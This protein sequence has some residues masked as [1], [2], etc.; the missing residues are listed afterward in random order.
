M[1]F[2]IPCPPHCSCELLLARVA[3]RVSYCSVRKRGKTNRCT[4]GR[5]DGLAGWG[6]LHRGMPQPTFLPLFMVLTKHKWGKQAPSGSYALA[7][8]PPK[9][10]AWCFSLVGSRHGGRQVSLGRRMDPIKN[11]KL[12]ATSKSPSHWCISLRNGLILSLQLTRLCRW[13]PAGRARRAIEP[14][15]SELGF[16][17]WCLTKCAISL[18]HPSSSSQVTAIWVISL[19]LALIDISV[20]RER[21]P[22]DSGLGG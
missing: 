5:T 13:A 22:P 2:F 3:A 12:L 10:L 11:P 9:T 18:A 16:I 7:A 19:T 15:G 21:F 8:L 4:S 14:Q 20:D 1:S 6:A 17:F